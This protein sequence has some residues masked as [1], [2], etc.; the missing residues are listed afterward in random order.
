[1]TDHGVL[2]LGIH[3]MGFLKT[4]QKLLVEEV[5]DTSDALTRLNRNDLQAIIG[6]GFRASMPDTSEIVRRAESDFRI[7]ESIQTDVLHIHDA[8]YPPQLREIWDPPYLLFCRGAIPPS[9]HP[10]LGV[11]GTRYPSGKARKAAF[12]LAMEVGVIGMGVVSGLARGIDTEAHNGALAGRGYTCAVMGTGADEI[13][14][15]EN[16]ALARTI[17]DSGGTLL[18]EYVP[19]TPPLRYH[20]PERNRI[21]SG[22]CR[23][24]A[25]VE[26]PARSGALITADFALD[27]GRD[28][29]VHSQGLHPLTGDG[30]MALAADG[31]SVIQ[32]ALE[33]LAEWGMTPG[34]TIIPEQ[35][36][37]DSDHTGKILAEFLEEELAGE[38]LFHQGASFRS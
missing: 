32:G 9:E 33:V 18:T 17:L 38:V 34:K 22:L 36:S 31:A 2:R 27:Q 19:S 21:L 8:A 11:V 25:V 20:F 23:G 1:M 28:I 26:A 24:V 3:R 6:S 5:M 37:G 12:S 10:F 15:A 35:R 14:P 7:L 29:F 13:Y 16:K 30:T 4:E